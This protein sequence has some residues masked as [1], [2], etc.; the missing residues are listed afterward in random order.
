MMRFASRP[1]ADDNVGADCFAIGANSTAFCGGD[2]DANKPTGTIKS[3]QTTSTAQKLR[4]SMKNKSSFSELASKIPIKM[5]TF[6]PQGHADLQRPTTA[7]NSAQSSVHNNGSSLSLHSTLAS[8]AG[9]SAHEYLEE[10]LVTEVSVLDRDRF[11]A[12]PEY[13][14]NQLNISEHL[15]KGSYSDVFEVAL[16]VSIFDEKSDDDIISERLGDL[17]LSTKSPSPMLYQ[18]KQEAN[19]K[20]ADDNITTRRRPPRARR[21]TISSSVRGHLKRPNRCDDRQVIY[22]M[23]CLR[24]QIR[25]DPEKF[26]IGAEDLVHET[27]LLATLDHPNIISVHGRAAGQLRDAFT[28]NDG[29]FIL[30][31]RLK[32][33]TL[34]DCIENWRRSPEFNRRGPTVRQIDIALC[35]AEAI[36][37]L[38]SKNI[39]YRD[40]KPTNVGFDSQGV[41]KLFDFGFAVGLP[42]KNYLDVS[43]TDGL[44]FDRCGTPRYMA[45]EI[46]LGLGYRSE[47]D[48][49]SYG[50]LL[51]EMCSLK[52]PFAEFKNVD[53]LER[54]VSVQGVRPSIKKEWPTLLSDTIKKCWSNSPSERP[55]MESVK[56]ALR[57]VKQ[58]S[59]CGDDGAGKK[60]RPPYPKA[61]RR[62]S[63]N[64]GYNYNLGS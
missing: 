40:L 12:I 14:K 27:A 1:A 25:S 57:E 23:K 38:H 33:E 58:A 26:I 52:K 18:K 7:P 39:V 54:A 43:N 16:Q 46:G 10:C 3:V 20:V 2:A 48:V 15:G 62:I 31:D 28:L 42:A 47:A 61:T 21:L 55:G 60:R 17:S 53:E 11:N 51:W 56:S 59:M 41:I 35:I 49:Y 34:K 64:M 29:Y 30:L 63:I 37:Y 36:A 45:P 9:K 22:A 24:P 44:L 6:K 8:E 4:K 5:K 32:K 19:A 50:I 13:Q